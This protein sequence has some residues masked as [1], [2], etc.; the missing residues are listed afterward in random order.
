M[1]RATFEVSDQH[2]FGQVRELEELLTGYGSVDMPDMNNGER[3]VVFTFNAGEAPEQKCHG[4]A[5][6]AAEQAVGA[7]S[8]AASVELVNAYLAVS[9]WWEEMREAADRI[10]FEAKDGPLPAETPVAA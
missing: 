5:L 3:R 7:V 6:R 10:G 1:V 9:S 2:T 8:R 4:W